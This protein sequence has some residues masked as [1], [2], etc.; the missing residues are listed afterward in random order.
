MNVYAEIIT[1]GDEILYGQITDTNSQWIGQELGKIGFR[2]IRKTSIGDS[3]EEILTA[4][5]EASQ[6]AD[7]VLTTGGLGPTKDD[8]TK[9]TFAEY[10]N[11]ELT[12]R[13]EVFTHIEALFKVKGRE[14][15]EL[16][17]QQAYVPA[18]GEV[19]H[20]AVGTA[21]GMWFPQGRKVYVSM[22]GV[23]H[24]MKKMMSDI[25]IPRL[26]QQFHT[27]FIY[28]KM[29]RTV[30]IPES[31]LAQQLEHWED[32]LP[33]HI[34]LAYLPRLGQVRLRLTA[35]GFD[36]E[37]LKMEVEEELY[38]IR[39]LLGEK[40]YAEEDIDLE[41]LVVEKL[42][43]KGLKLATAESC[44]GGLLADQI[45]NIPGVSAVYQG[46]IVSYSNEVKM[47]QLGVKEE[48]LRTH[49]AVSEETAR[50]MAEQ[51]R[52]RYGADFGISTTGIAG[53]DGGTEEKPVGTIW[54]ACAT[55]KETYTQL[56]QLT[57]DRILNINATAT[58]VLKLLW[59]HID[60]IG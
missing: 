2:I 4:L 38:K 44:T 36:L 43:Q 1:I 29:V 19:I 32:A 3:R 34:K 31:I 22:P 13:E 7:V 27:P 30:G 59:K 15:T 12:F 23:P 42:K 26:Q 52:E 25:I 14:I 49:G 6:R 47:S 16:N 37:Q 41:V 60:T 17:R 18:L 11:E 39:P 50:E 57:S 35:T 58:A 24:E 51:V 10:F 45:T 33:E 46:G 9:H 56:L 8:I 5:K 54:I 40:L 55:P 21:P 20:N 53:P 48:T 28:H